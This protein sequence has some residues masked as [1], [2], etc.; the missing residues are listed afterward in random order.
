[1]I[2]IHTHHIIDMIESS[3]KEDVIA[4]LKL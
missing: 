1:M 4:W 2:D 3:D